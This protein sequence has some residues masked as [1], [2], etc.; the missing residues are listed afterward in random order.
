MVSKQ[1][2]RK[3]EDKLARREA[4]LAA[5]LALWNE[6]TFATLTMAEVAGRCGLAK[7]TL[8]LYFA[9]KEELL[10]ALLERELSTWFA[11]IDRLLATDDAPWDAARASAAICASLVD[12][13]AFTRLL[14]IAPGILEYNL[15]PERA[16]A[17]KEQMRRGAVSTGALLERRLPFLTPG[18][19]G[20]LLLSLHALVIGLRQMA[21][22]GP[23]VAAVL[24]QPE[25]APLRLEFD[26]SLRAMLAMLLRGLEARREGDRA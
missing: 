20:Q 25:M 7:G 26:Q 12:R 13:V 15:S 22:P 4:I 16:L 19:G 2:A 18:E 6:R 14:T 8:Y 21:D 23:V 10:L 1:R 3:N 9:T 17:Y 5:A 11:A 24:A